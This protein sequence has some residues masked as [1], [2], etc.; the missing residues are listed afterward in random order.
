MKRR[1]AMK[2]REAGNVRE[3][4]TQCKSRGGEGGMREGVRIRKGRV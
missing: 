1:D 4:E 2:G 3:R